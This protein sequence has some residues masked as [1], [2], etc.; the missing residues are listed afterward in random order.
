MGTLDAYFRFS[1]YAL[2]ATSFAMLVATRQLDWISLIG[3]TAALAAGWMIDRGSCP[4]LLSARAVNLLRIG[5]LLVL[6]FDWQV[7]ETPPALVVI[8][9]VL[10]VSACKL[11]ERK[12]LRDWLWLYLVAFF[13]LLLAA[14]MTI[15]AT[16]LLLLVIFL[17]AAIS[18]LISFEI[19]RAS[20]EFNRQTI[21]AQISPPGAAASDASDSNPGAEA[22]ERRTARTVFIDPEIEIW[23]ERG[24]ARKLIGRPR[25]GAVAAFSVVALVVILLLATPL[26]LAMPRLARASLGN[27]MLRTESLSGFSNTV[28]LGEVARVKLNPQVVMRVRVKFPPGQSGASL[29]W[30]GVSFDYYD[31]QS[32]S[33]SD[34][35]LVPVRRFGDS[36]QVEPPPPFGM[37]TEQNFFLEPLSLATIFAAPRV[38]FVRDLRALERDAGD[39][40]WTQGYPSQRLTYTVYS[41]TWTPSDAALQLDSSRYYPPEIR[42]RYLQLPASRDPRIDELAAEISAGATTP[43]EI[44]RRIEEYLRTS[45]GYTLNLRRTNDGDPVADFLFNVRAGHCEYFAT[46]MALLLRSRRIPARLVN[47][48]Q[49][50]EYSDVAGAYTVRQSDAHSWVEVYF[51]DHGWVAFDPTP[52]AGLSSYGTGIMAS[53]RHY[54]EALELFW[55]EKVIGFGT[56]DQ[57]ALFAGLQQ[58]VAAYQQGTAQRWFSWT[59]NISKLFSA[60]QARAG[61]DAGAPSEGSWMSRPALIFYG[62]IA[63]AAAIIF[64]RR[65][66]GSWRF[67]LQRDRA[68]SAVAF[69]QEMLG[70]LERAGHRREASATPREFASTL[71]WPE[72]E[73]LTLLYERA[74]YSKSELTEAEVAEIARLLRSIKD[75]TGRK[76]WSISWSAR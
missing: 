18:T 31:G 23:R 63:A 57:I 41:S 74:R 21:A 5:Y 66:R 50:G 71:K 58:T 37:M 39:G 32:W 40:L 26:F 1:S 42:R 19:C 62:L 35:S 3:Y 7:L 73:E 67:Q 33:L 75:V 9:F 65:R 20:N 60:E 6:I 59:S 24:E 69:Y 13:M 16:F 51:R 61:N 25:G 34:D 11:L 36:F 4:P 2:L 55:Q 15:D 53:L 8:H 28:R 22:G 70:A 29:R 49:M 46:A 38:N 43:L 10:F 45:Y 47:G 17:F 64:W 68:R 44:A 27:R 30:R 48:F 56:L 14:G 12:A 76:R 54:F 52:A 72:V